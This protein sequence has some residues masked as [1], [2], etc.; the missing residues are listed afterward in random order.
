MMAHTGK[1]TPLACKPAWVHTVLTVPTP[2][3]LCSLQALAQC[4]AKEGVLL[5]CPS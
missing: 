3:A 1:L 2:P 5:P 4:G